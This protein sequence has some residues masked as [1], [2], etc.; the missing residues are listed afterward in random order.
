MNIKILFAGLLAILGMSMSAMSQIQPGRAINITITGVPSEEMGRFGTGIFPVSEAGMINLPF[1]GQIRVAGMSSDAV[2]SMLEARYKAA[3][4][5]RSPTF[6]V[7]DND[8]KR[9][10]E[11]MVH[12][13]GFVRSPGPKP[14]NRN[15][16]LWQAIQASGG[17]NEFGSMARVKLTRNGRMKQYDCTKE[18]FKQIPLEPDDTIDVPQKDW[19]GR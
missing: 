2:Q 13:G 14:Y 18:Q 7:I 10:V 5:Y 4:I 19:L 6:Q 3:G 16:T 11:Q 12:V 9:I 1:L 17:A 15:L 8:A